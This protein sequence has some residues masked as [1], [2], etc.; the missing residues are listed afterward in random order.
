MLGKLNSS[1]A[2][3]H[4]LFLTRVLRTRIHCGYVD[5]LYKPLKSDAP[6]F[7]YVFAEL[8]QKNRSELMV[9]LATFVSKAL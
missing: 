3:L 4:V 5:A 9:R 7:V 8:C 6:L 1:N 2:M